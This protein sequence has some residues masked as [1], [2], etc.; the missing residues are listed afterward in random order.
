MT[1]DKIQEAILESAQAEA[2][3]IVRAAEMQAEEWKAA[4]LEQAKQ[5]AEQQFR[6]RTRAIEEDLA[7]KVTQARGAS[8]KQLL[9]RRNSVMN[10]V[11]DKARNAI[12]ALP[13]AEYGGIMR[14][15][16]DRCAEE[17]GG[18]VRV[19]PD[20]AA[21]FAGLVQEVNAGRSASVQLALDKDN[22]L[23][24]RGGF[25]FVGEGFEVDQTLDKVLEGVRH[26]LA[27]S[28]ASSL[29]SA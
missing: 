28:I 2:A 23:P 9:E 24:K 26:E 22:P 27:P 7:R 20:D 5:D 16:M 3:R 29:F 25:V 11:F 17:S 14:R 8:G 15:W 1:M 21:V 4:Q 13:S 19:H 6:L 10:T 12:L 18:Q